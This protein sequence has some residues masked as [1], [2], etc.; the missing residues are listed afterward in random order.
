MRRPTE[1]IQTLTWLWVCEPLHQWGSPSV[2]FLWWNIAPHSPS[3]FVNL[4]GLKRVYKLC[5]PFVKILWIAWRGLKVHKKLPNSTTKWNSLVVCIRWEEQCL[6]T[7]EI[8]ETEFIF[9]NWITNSLLHLS[10]CHRIVQQC[11]RD[12]MLPHSWIC[13]WN[14]TNNLGVFGLPN[15]RKSKIHGNYPLLVAV[16]SQG[17]SLG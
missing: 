17:G 11:A 9:A 5:A 3:Y 4:E 6:Q 7:D 8:Q 2:E 15:I 14:T 12:F 16:T 10:F 1:I 13:G